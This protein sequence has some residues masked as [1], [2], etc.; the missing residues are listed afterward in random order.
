MGIRVKYKSFILGECMDK[1]EG[2]KYGHFPQA[3]FCKRLEQSHS[4]LLFVVLSIIKSSDKDILNIAMC[5]I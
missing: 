3:V 2:L 4:E 1:E 5:M